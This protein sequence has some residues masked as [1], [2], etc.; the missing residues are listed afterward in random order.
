MTPGHTAARRQTYEPSIV[1]PDDRERLGT[2]LRSFT[3]RAA[4]SASGFSALEPIRLRRKRKD[5]SWA[6]LELAGVSDVRALHRCVACARGG[7]S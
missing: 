2:H 4:A 5:G 6:R 3:S 1:H 7:Q